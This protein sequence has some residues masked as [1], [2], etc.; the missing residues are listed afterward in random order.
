MNVNILNLKIS[1][2]VVKE[3]GA[4]N[5]EVKQNAANAVSN[6]VSRTPE[7]GEP[8]SITAVYNAINEAGGVADVANVDIF[9]QTGGVYSDYFINLD[10]YMSPDGRFINMPHDVIWEVRL[11]GD[12]IKGVILE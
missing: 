6:L 2:E 5:F 11:V 8:F 1:Y 9:V 12:D 3:T 10:E 4:D 7:I